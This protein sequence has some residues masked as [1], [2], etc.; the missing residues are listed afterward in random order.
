[1]LQGMMARKIGM[2]QIFEDDGRVIPVTVLEA[3]PVTVVQ[4]KTMEKDGCDQVQVGYEA[5]EERKVNRPMK[6]H[7]RE[8]APT[9]LLREFKVEDISQVEVGQSYG[10]ELFSEGEM[11]KVS[12]TS[13]GKGFTNNLCR[14]LGFLFPLGR[15]GFWFIVGG[16][17][18]QGGCH[19]QPPEKSRPP[20]RVFCLFYIICSRCLFFWFGEAKWGLI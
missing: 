16:L 15:P 7:F 11:V 1:M 9:R 19:R 14:A 17:I 3:G 20:V 8:Q 13:K 18:N 2:T 12:G 10:V 5:I 6:G 4:K